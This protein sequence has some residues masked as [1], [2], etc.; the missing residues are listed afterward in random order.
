MKETTVT[1]GGVKKGENPLNIRKKARFTQTWRRRKKK[2][3]EKMA[4]DH[5]KTNRKK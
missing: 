2:K 5:E 1:R 3:K 4:I